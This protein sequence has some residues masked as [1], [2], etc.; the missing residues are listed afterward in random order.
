MLQAGLVTKLTRTSL[1]A[2]S[3][4]VAAC[5]ADASEPVQIVKSMTVGIR[6]LDLTRQHDVETFYFRVRRAADRV[7]ERGVSGDW[8]THA[9]SVDPACVQRAIAGA[10]AS[11]HQP[12]V[13]AYHIRRGG[14]AAPEATR[15]G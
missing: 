8:P 7:C 15:P 3:L 14:I 6:D 5:G 1:A 10:V 12:L 4:A 2:L 13:T 9:G 11:V